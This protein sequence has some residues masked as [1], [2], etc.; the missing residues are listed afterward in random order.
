MY[1][2]APEAYR[3]VFV[4]DTYKRTINVYDADEERP[5]LPIYL[6]FDNLLETLDIEEK[7]DE[8][9]TALRPYG[10]DELSIRAANPLGTDWMYDLSYFIANGDIKDPLASRAVLRNTN[11]GSSVI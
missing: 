3:C 11:K 7:S 8:L 5:T 10:A 2:T 4:F 6:D 1:N 9:V